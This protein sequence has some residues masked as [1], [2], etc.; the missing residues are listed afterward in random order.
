MSCES[1]FTSKVRVAKPVDF[2][3]RFVVTIDVEDSDDD[4]GEQASFLVHSPAQLF[5]EPAEDLAGRRY[6]FTVDRTVE[7]GRTR[8][9]ALR[10]IRES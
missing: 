1:R 5:H 8:W 10:V 7:D 3:P 9:S 2:D 4:V 6:Q